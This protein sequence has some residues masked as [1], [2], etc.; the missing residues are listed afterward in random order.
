MKVYCRKCRYSECDRWLGCFYRYGTTIYT[1]ARKHTSLTDTTLN[2]IE[3]NKNGDC[4]NYKR[5]WWQ[6]WK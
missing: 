6:I 5:K 4:K 1:G 2:K 3:Q